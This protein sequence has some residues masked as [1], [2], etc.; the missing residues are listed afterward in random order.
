MA[1]ITHDLNL[2]GYLLASGLPCSRAFPNCR[3]DPIRIQT[4][5][6]GHRSC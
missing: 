4:I 2:S 5:G 6:Q 1:F 3:K